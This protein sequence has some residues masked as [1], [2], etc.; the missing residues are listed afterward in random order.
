MP[1]ERYRLADL[2]VDAE[3]GG[4]VRDGLRL[5]LPPLTF[6]LLVALLRRAPGVARRE[7]L[8]DEVWEGVVV[9]DE[10]LS[11]RVRLL[12]EALGDTASAPRYV[13]SVR[14][15]GYRVAARVE[16]L[17]EDRRELTTIAV[18]PFAN[19]GGDP[20][21]D[22]LCEGLAEEIISALAEV[23]GLRV[24]ARTSS[25][26]VARMGLDACRAGE[27]LG[28]GSLLEGSVRR[29]GERV[30][31]TVQLIETTHG[32]HLW[33]ERYERELRD[34][35]ELED[36]IAAAVAARLRSDL[37][38]GGEPRHRR[39][40][41]PE[42]H[43]AYLEGRYHFARATPEA[44]GR[45]VEC[46]QRAI[47]LDPSHARAYDGLAELHWY[48]GFYGGAPPRDAFGQSTWYALQALELD[49]T[50]ADTHALLGMLRKELD[51]NWPEVDRE[52]AR[53][54]ELDPDSPEVRIRY[55]ISGLLP[56]G[57]VEEALAEVERV[58]AR[59]PLSVTVHWWC[60]AMALLARR[61]ERTLDE[62]RVILRLEPEH[63]LGYWLVGM[64]LEQMGELASAAEA[65]ERAIELSGGIPFTLGYGMVPIGRAG[66]HDTVRGILRELEEAAASRYVP[67][68]TFAF[69]H[70]GLG[71]WDQALRFLDRAVEE[72]DPII[73]PIKTYSFLDPIR[74]DRR[75]HRLLEKMNLA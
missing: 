20:A 44:L 3:S 15:W 61:S 8:V 68:T 35:L 47:A 17:D 45:A 70:V 51:Y 60:G 65:M 2:V 34:A 16:R 33:S 13:E 57:R 69:G 73:M 14:G 58:L 18:L 6:A 75:F 55:A 56:H 32:G 30:R 19:L 37:G 10:T 39:A 5:D 24:I 62:G 12:R 27:R 4:V 9:G 66:R 74:D 29:S 71:E 72:R 21:D 40:V 49:E 53:A 48:L 38:R 64:G 41:D 63:F 67:P 26:V 59:D 7:D 31:V 23:D 46:Y 28:A 1:S 11:Q 42:A 36:D 52:L 54:R 25:F 50:L 22:P 43:Q